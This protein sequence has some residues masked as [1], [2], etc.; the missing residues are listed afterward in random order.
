MKPVKFK[1]VITATADR[2]GQ[3][4]EVVT[5]VMQFYF[6]ALR[7]SLTSL[8]H[9]RIQ[10][11]NLGTFSLKPHTIE[12]KLSAKQSQLEKLSE[13]VS[14][15]DARREEL[16]REIAQIEQASLIM[17]TEK[18]R[19]QTIKNKIHEQWGTV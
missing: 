16:L 18:E 12:R 4:P 3:P 11:L 15:H 5:A 17:K 6:K 14:R 9:P 7:A 8:S 1:E 2:I 10:V 19:R 13:G